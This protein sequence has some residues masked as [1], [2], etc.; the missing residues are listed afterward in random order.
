MIISLI[1]EETSEEY[2][3]KMIKKYG[4][5]ENLEK[6]LN[7]TKRTILHVDLENWKYL[8]ENP[9]ETIKLEKILITDNVN[10]GENEVELLN[11]IKNDNPKSV[12][13]VA[14]KINKDPANITYKINQLANE[15]LISFKKGLKNSKIPV[16]NYD[17]IEIAI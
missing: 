11:I 7:E 1:R 10:I 9:E 4:S 3:E 14:N 8:T 16:L 2:D 5:I 15:G 17:K 6:I 12:R 13:D